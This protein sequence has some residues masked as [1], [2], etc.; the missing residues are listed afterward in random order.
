MCV[1][2]VVQDCVQR[3]WLPASELMVQPDPICLVVWLSVWLSYFCI[4][5]V[6][7]ETRLKI[8]SL[9]LSGGLWGKRKHQRLSATPNPRGPVVIL[10]DMPFGREQ[11]G[12]PDFG[13]DVLLC[14]C[15]YRTIK[16]Q[17]RRDRRKFWDSTGQCM[18]SAVGLLYYLLLDWPED[19]TLRLHP[20]PS[21][22]VRSSL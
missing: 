1:P 12:S 13:P 5:S 8:C 6:L 14:P 11:L 4:S 21:S 3:G 10:C 17:G 16:H 7:Q 9:K 20:R 19:H 2:G 18:L 15:S 22:G